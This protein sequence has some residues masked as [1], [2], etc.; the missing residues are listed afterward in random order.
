VLQ[1]DCVPGSKSKMY[2]VWEVQVEAWQ[3]GNRQQA[4]PWQVAGCRRRVCS[5]HCAVQC[6]S[7][8]ETVALNPV[9]SSRGSGIMCHIY[10]MRQQAKGGGERAARQAFRR[11]R[12]QCPSSAASR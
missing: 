12:V 11:C 9:C 3:A 5:R 8:I 4:V 7:Q 6:R 1:K 10:L 2:E